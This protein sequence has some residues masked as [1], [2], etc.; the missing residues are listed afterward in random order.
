MLRTLI[1][2]MLLLGCAGC[3]SRAGDCPAGGSADCPAPAGQSGM[4]I[5]GGGGL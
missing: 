5:S 1:A 2:L 3:S 4:Y